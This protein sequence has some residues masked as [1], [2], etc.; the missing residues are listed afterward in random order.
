MNSM[1]MQQQNEEL[2]MAYEECPR[3]HSNHLR[4]EYKG[5]DKKCLTCSHVVYNRGSGIKIAG[6]NDETCLICDAPMPKTP[7]GND[8]TCSSSCEKQHVKAK[9][10]YQR[11]GSKAE[12][13][14]R[15]WAISLVCAGV[16]ASD[17]APFANCSPIALSKWAKSDPVF[18]G[19][20][21][22]RDYV[23][24]IPKVL[25]DLREGKEPEQIALS[26]R[27]PP[28]NVKLWADEAVRSGAMAPVQLEL[29]AV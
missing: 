25:Q 5:G 27:L 4:P 11:N 9:D 14:L 17:V 10:Y 6:V 28:E 15:R 16:R 13:P 26:R 3:C 1:K 2:Q 24:D 22:M 20:L 8:L 12:L 18:G 29:K 23:S 19:V 7:A 21:Y